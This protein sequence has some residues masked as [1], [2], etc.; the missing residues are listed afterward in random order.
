MIASERFYPIR[1]PLAAACAGAAVAILGGLIG[2]GGAEFRLP[3][4]IAVF[5]LYPHRAVRINLL[6]SFVVLVVSA[7]SRLSF[8]HAV[9]LADQGVE[10]VGMLFGGI[11]AAWFGASLLSRIPKTRTIGVIAALLLAVAVLLVVETMLTGVTWE[12]LS[13]ASPWRGPVAVI[14]GLFVGVISSLLGVA[15]GE[16][17]IPILIFVFGADIR[18]AGTA[19]VLISLPVVLTGVARHWST[20]HYRSQ[21]LLAFLVLPMCIGSLVGATVGGYLAA[22]APTDA[23]RIALAAILAASSLKLWSK[24]AG[25]PAPRPPEG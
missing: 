3:I 14:A 13:R 20:G 1:R 5:A 16:F 23:V 8:V 10:I 15:G 22:R 21:T 24:R 11:V 12:L 17:I 9:N 7:A 4:L 25:A 6:V 19:S 2:L 18:T